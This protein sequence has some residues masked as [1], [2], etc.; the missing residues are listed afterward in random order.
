MAL[1]DEPVLFLKPSSAVVA[2]GSSI[3]YPESSSRVDYEAELGIVI[4]TEARNV[5]ESEA[6]S[7]VL[8]Y[9]AFNA[10]T[11]RDLQSKDGQWTRAKGFDTFAPFGPYIETELKNPND[12]AIQAILNGKVVQ[13]SRTSDMIFP[14]EKII[15]FV[16]KVMTLYPGDVIATGTPEGIGSMKK[17]DEIVIRIEGLEDLVNDVK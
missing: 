11:A 16:S 7:V 9:T 14:V 3:V 12:L 6:A 1:P 2:S 8:G 10:V 15:S 4:K 17:G 13:D 5:S